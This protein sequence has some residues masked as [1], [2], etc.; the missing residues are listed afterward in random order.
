MDSRHIGHV[1]PAVKPYDLAVLD[2]DV[3]DCARPDVA[4]GLPGVWGEPGQV[5]G[6]P[7]EN[8]EATVTVHNGVISLTRERVRSGEGVSR[9]PGRWA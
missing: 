7:V 6:V 4:P 3:P 5:V 9:L 1:Y 2:D 8:P